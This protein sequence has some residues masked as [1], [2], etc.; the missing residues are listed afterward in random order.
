MTESE[1]TAPKEDSVS[2]SQ[3]RNNDQR[4]FQKVNFVNCNYMQ[5]NV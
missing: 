4:D 5:K 2:M 3:K 1:K